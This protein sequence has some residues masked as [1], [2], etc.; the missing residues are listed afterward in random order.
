MIWIVPI[1][2][3]IMS[4]QVYS[5]DPSLE[6]AAFDLGATRLQVLREVTLP[7]LSPGIISGGLFAFLL[8]W[9][10]FPAFAFFH[11]CRSDG[12]GVAL[13]QDGFGLHA[14][15]AHLGLHHHGERGLAAARGLSGLARQPH[16]PGAGLTLAKLNETEGRQDM[17][18][19]I[20]GRSVIVTGASKGIGKGIARVFANQ[21]GQGHGGGA[22]SGGRRGYGC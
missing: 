22:H 17:L 5:F 2:I 6:E 3:L 8:S 4:I 19:S 14:H 16:A 9:S 15:G 12:A 1:V 7:I 21:G 10:N 20:S 13:R 18:T 11:R